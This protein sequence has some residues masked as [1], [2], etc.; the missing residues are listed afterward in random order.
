MAVGIEYATYVIKDEFGL[1]DTTYITTRVVNRAVRRPKTA[2]D[3]ANTIKTKSVMIDVLRNDSLNS[4]SNV[5]VEIVKAPLNGKAVMTNDMRVLYTPNAN[6]CHSS[7]PDV[8]QYALCTNGGCDTASVSV[9]VVCD[10]IKVFNAFSPNNDGVN[11]YFVIEGIENFPNNT[12]T[13]YN[14]W[15]SEVMKTKG[16]KNDWAGQWNGSHLPD[17]TYF[18]IFEDGEGNQQSGYVQIQR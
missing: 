11:D 15:G 8:F 2:N 4:S 12:V 10:K 1:T 14:R 18:Y 3:L 13:I 16:Y 7:K 5:R 9:I 17:G 6:Y